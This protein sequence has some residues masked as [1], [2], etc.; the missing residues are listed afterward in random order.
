MP[1][2]KTIAEVHCTHDQLVALED[3]KP[4]P[5]N[6]NVHPPAQI[7]RLAQI[8]VKQGWRAPITVSNLSGRIV[9]GHC[10]LLAAQRAKQSHAPVDFQDYATPEL[11]KADLVAD[12]QIAEL[13]NLDTGKLADLF[14]D[15]DMSAF[16]VSMT[17]FDEAEFGEIMGGGEPENPYTLK[18]E[19]PVYTPTGP[20]PN[21]S[22]LLDDGK[23]TELL[24]EIDACVDIPA[25]V[26]DFLRRSAERHVVFDFRN[27]AEYYAHAPK[28]VQELME[29]SALVII[30]FDK[31]VEDGYVRLTKRLVD[32]Y[33][34][35]TSDG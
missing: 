8:I 14:A 16:D 7:T 35:D 1:A 27:I 24:S 4:N 34:E 31:A 10:R 6:P 21:L 9:R 23:A 18:V 2:T 15:V 29:R 19:S 12:N 30:D 3:L 13:A 26:G 22:E 17:G 11:E 32:L 28:E 25:E 33:E 20:Q 5:D